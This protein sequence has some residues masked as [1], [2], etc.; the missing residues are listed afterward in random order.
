M[1]I[2]LVG[3][4][5][6]DCGKAEYRQRDGGYRWLDGPVQIFIRKYLPDAEIETLDRNS[7]L[8]ESQNRKEKRNRR[9]LTGLKGHA[10][11]AFYV[12]EMAK[13]RD[14]YTAAVYVDA[15]KDQGASQKT[16][17]EC[18]TRY[19]EICGQLKTGFER[20][21]IG[22]Y[23]SI[24]P[25][26]MIECWLLADPEAFRVAFGKVPDPQ[27]PKN[28]EL[29]W[30]DKHDPDSDYPKNQL[31]RI[32]VQYGEKCSMEAYNTIAEAA[33]RVTVETNCPI[34]F[35]DFARQLRTLK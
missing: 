31:E 34:S 11:K 9:T 28:P 16:R 4:G 24:V 12:S 8:S 30:G 10:V 26:K 23:L 1:K 3:E 2:F 6:T 13:E 27:L 17:H 19:D 20:S 32:L 14:C 33:N 5:P 29:L 7:F 25:V 15:D 21:G 22:S 35:S 18:Q